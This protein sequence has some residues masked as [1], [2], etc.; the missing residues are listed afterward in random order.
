MALAA[1]IGGS[2]IFTWSAFALFVVFTATV[3]V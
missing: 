1:V 3:A 2:Y